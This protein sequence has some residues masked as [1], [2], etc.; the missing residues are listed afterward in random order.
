MV[1]PKHDL[2]LGNLEGLANPNPNARR[3][4]KDFKKVRNAKEV[5]AED[6]DDE[7][8]EGENEGE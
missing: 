8:P 1:D 5:E 6:A 3:Q 4:F 2:R 7:G